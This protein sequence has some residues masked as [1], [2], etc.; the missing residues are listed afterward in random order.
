M[1]SSYYTITSSE[2]LFV[3]NWKEKATYFNDSFSHNNASLIINGSV[4]P[5]LI[6]N[7]SVLPALIINGSVL[8][9]LIINGS[10]LPALIFSLRKDLIR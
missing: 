4:L 8:P 7:G 1:Q 10:V 6:I 9:A 2:N 3:L 5:A